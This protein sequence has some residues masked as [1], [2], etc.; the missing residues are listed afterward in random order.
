VGA[1]GASTIQFTSIPQTYTDLKVSLSSRASGTTGNIQ[2]APNGSTANRSAL[3]LL[4]SGSSVIS[5]ASS[6][7]PFIFSYAALSSDTS[8]T[9]G[10]ISYYIPNYTSSNEKAVSVDGVTENNATTAFAFLSTSLLGT[11]AITS[12][13]LT[14]Y[15]GGTFVQYSTATLYGIKNS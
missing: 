6:S 3:V 2:F 7:Q 12:I 10:N 9:F 14:L 11:S 8:S 13:S 5:A 15:F 1:G 4:N